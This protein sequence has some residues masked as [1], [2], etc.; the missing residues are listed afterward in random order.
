[1]RAPLLFGSG[2]GLSFRLAFCWLLRCRFLTPLPRGL[3][4]IAFFGPLPLDM[5]VGCVSPHLGRV[6]G[7]DPRV[8]LF[9]ARSGGC[10]HPLAVDWGQFSFWFGGVIMF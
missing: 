1:M 3:F 10:P 4:I 6:L 5:V 7:R 2:N 9:L 8:F